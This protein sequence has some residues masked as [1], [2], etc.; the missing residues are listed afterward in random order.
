MLLRRITIHVKEQNW[1]AV[2]LD[3]VIVVVG[4]Y[5]GVWVSNYQESQS[6]EATRQQVV[7]ILRDDMFLVSETTATFASNVREGLAEFE[8]KRSE[9]ETP[10]P[11]FYRIPGSDRPPQELWNLIQQ[12]QLT[13]LMSPSLI[14]DLGFF[15]SEQQGV[16]NKYVRYITFVEQHV[17]PGLKED[18][19][20]FYRAD[21]SRLKPRYEAN[22]DRLIEW[23]AEAEK[24]SIWQNCLAIRLQ[25]PLE[26]T[27]NCTP[28]FT[29]APF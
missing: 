21:T 22:M 12:Q 7:E 28:D 16:S 11:Y 13:D 15:Y 23:V 29:T 24:L 6:T 5:C 17:L 8:L 26:K 25:T 1:F 2:A 27:E 10:P 3:F 20:Y 14:A 4:V 18:A 9:G 19:G